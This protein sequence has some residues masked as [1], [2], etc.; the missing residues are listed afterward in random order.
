MSEHTATRATGRVYAAYAFDFDGTLADTADVNLR[1]VQASLA[2]HGITVPLAWVT[3]DPAFTA[4]QLRRRLRIDPDALPDDTFVE[5]ARAYWFSHTDRIRP[6]P[7]AAAAAR[8]AADHAGVAVVSANYADIVRHGLS[9]IHL[10]DLPWTVVGR[11]DVPR[12]KPAPDPYLHAAGLLGVHPS[13][14][15][16][17]EDTDEGVIAA[18]AAGMDVIDI[19]HR[20]WQ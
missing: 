3:A 20:P 5:A 6:I 11:E 18:G 7:A 9:V 17:H 14:C 2:A 4:P 8:A 13:A 19:R 10:D 12:T 15:L 16:A 1:A